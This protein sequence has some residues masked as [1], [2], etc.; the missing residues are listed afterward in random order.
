MKLKARFLVTL[1]LATFAATAVTSTQS[2][3]LVAHFEFEDADNLGHDSSGNENHADVTDVEQVE[4]Q[5]GMAGFF[6]ESLPSSFVV[7]DGLNGFTGKPGVTLA[8]WV[9]LDEN[10]TGFD[11][12]I[13]QDSGGCCDNRILLHP[14]TKAPYINLS[15]HSDRHLTSSPPFEIDEWMHVA[16]TGEDIDGEAEANVYVNGV[17][18]DESPEIFPEMDDG[19]EWSTYLGA[20]EGGTA[21]LLTG[22]LDDVRVYEGALNQD[23]IKE[24]LNPPSSGEVALIVEEGVVGNQ[25][26]GGALGMDFVVNKA[27]SVSEL[28]AFDSES[29]EL[30]LPITV[31]LWSRNDG[32]TPD[33]FDDDSGGEILASIQLEDDEGTLD[34]GTRFLALEEAVDLLPGAYTIV[35]WGYGDDEMN[36]NL[37]GRDAAPEGL[38]ITENDA[39]TFVGQSRFGDPGNNGQ[40]PTE[41]D[42]GPVNRYG[43]GSFKFTAAGGPCDDDG[44]PDFWEEANGLDAC[45]PSDAALDPDGDTL[46]N[47]QEFEKRTD[48]NKA[49]TD[50]DGLNDNVETNTGT[51]VGATDTGTSPTEADSDEDGLNDGVET[52]TGSFVGANDTGTNPNLRDSDGDGTPDGVEAADDSR[53]PNKPD[54]PSSALVAH[55]E[56]EDP[57]NLGLDS[58]GMENHAEVTDVAQVEGKFGQGGF[59]DETLPSSFVKEGG[60][61]GFTGKPG[62]TLAAWVKLDEA[63]SGFDGI[64]SQDSGACCDNR[65]LLHPD[66]SA[67]INLS[68]HSDRHLSSGPPF[69]FDVWTHIAMTGLDVDGDAEARVYVNGVEVDDSP[70]IFPEMDDGS[71]WNTYLGAGEAG[72]VHLLTGALDDVR[73]YQGA[74]SPEEI[75]GLLEGGP[76]TEFEITAIEKSNGELTLTWNSAPGRVYAVEA[77]TDLADPVWLEIDDGVESEGDSTQ[78][79]DDDAA[80]VGGAEAYYRVREN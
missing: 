3:E 13:S 62:V 60:L 31:E 79:T 34:G 16:M 12:I 38:T 15:E 21:H 25:N 11:G 7:L 22:A 76:T 14:D 80:R 8:A 30:L 9:K 54:Q 71:E 1:A 72:N 49:D 53:D 46:T 27:I 69:E 65:I 10:S 44:I 19:S 58:S 50:G 67:F 5:F 24:L 45:D 73:I 42:G 55:Y 47:L 2:A 63:T 57:N 61:S 35:G 51:W 29:D 20:G 68:E 75:M 78:F 36:Y 70:Q 41:L 48:P 28:G 33:V 32:G 23:E 26:F 77:T 59:F 4:G 74:L 66:H 40:W 52:N 18:L 39:I 6:D 37:E 64:I 43:A 17:L 56:F